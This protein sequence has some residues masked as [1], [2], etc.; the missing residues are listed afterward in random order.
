M[1]AAVL[2]ITPPPRPVLRRPRLARVSRQGYVLHATP[3]SPDPNV[4]GVNLTHG[5]GQHCAF[6][7]VRG[8]ADYTGDHELVVYTNTAERLA[9]EL[10]AR[11]RKPRAVYVSPA[12]DPFLPDGELQSATT[13]VVEVLAE[14]GVEAWL[15]TRGLIRPAS[16]AVLAKYRDFV[17]V[18][19]PLTTLDRERQRVLE[20]WMASPKV[21]IKQ[22]AALRRLGISVQVMIEPLIPGV[23]DG[24]ENLRPL[25]A[26]LAQVGVRHLT[27]SYLSL[28]EGGLQHLSAALERL[29]YSE[30]L[31][32]DYLTGP[33]M[34]GPGLPSLR[35]LPRP[36]RQRGY[37]TVMA[38]A[39][40]QGLT[41]NV[42]RLTNPDFA[43]P[44]AAPPAKQRLLPLTF[45][46][47]DAN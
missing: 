31:L 10:D 46:T 1:V 16:L 32:A 4:P 20:P 18:T 23:T 5:C 9:A 22:I 27:A 24:S 41:V 45:P 17:K 3:F 26:A 21:R 2:P 15:L 38:L 40:E 29:G 34:T 14:R 39:S 19:A 8:L 6:C 43:P 13:R 37:A 42:C 36:R 30:S 25:M 44:P 11:V 28:R 33:V 12:T 35:Y 47:P 7:A